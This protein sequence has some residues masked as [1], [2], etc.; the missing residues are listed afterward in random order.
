MDFFARHYEKLILAFCLLLLLVGIVF[1]ALSATKTSS[2]LAENYQKARRNVEGGKLVDAM[3]ISNYNL[4]RY[5]NDPRK[6][7]N[8]LGAEGDQSGKGSM[9]EAGRMIICSNPECSR[10]LLLSADVCPFCN[11]KQPELSKG[12]GKDEDTDGDGIPDLVEQKYEFLNYRDPRDATMDQ[13]NDGFLNIE[14]IK[15]GTNPDDD[16]EFPAL[17]LLL[18][19]QH[20]FRPP[21][22]IT[23]VDVDKNRSDDM[24]KWDVAFKGVDP[25]T[26]RPRRFTV[27]V[28]ETVLN[29]FKVTSA[30]FEGE[31]DAAIPFAVVVTEGAD[32][33]EYTMKL[34]EDVKAKKNN[35]VFMYLRTR[36]KSDILRF[37]R[38]MRIMCQEGQ[39][40][41][42]RKQRGSGAS[43]QAEGGNRAPSNVGGDENVVEYYRVIKVDAANKTCQ[44]AK[45][46][47]K[48]GEAGQTFDIPVFDE[49]NDRD[50]IPEENN[51]GDM[52]EGDMPVPGSEG[53]PRQNRRRPPR[54]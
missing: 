4:E 40:F 26:R 45:L 9:L 48:G 46:S 39:E 37:G 41:M 11:T 10:I 23:L 18:R 50:F 7:C 49:K 29:R 53:G 14:E 30:G 3:D 13:D 52:T 42:L 34:N 47:G 16:S 44:V 6:A 21:L 27:R 12:T 17:A 32:A 19:V 35:V 28:G 36:K 43:K 31:G 5:F 2:E 8:I 33:E 38:R 1:V 54:P 22:G 24:N 25:R 51:R 15:A 20:V